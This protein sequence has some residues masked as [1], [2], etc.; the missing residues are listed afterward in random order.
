VLL[1]LL[2]N[3]AGSLQAADLP[4]PFLASGRQAQNK[5]VLRGHRDRV[6]TLAFTADGH[7]L[8]SVGQDGT[9]RIWET[10]SGR[11]VVTIRAYS[12]NVYGLAI[13]P[14]GAQLATASGGQGTEAQHQK[15]GALKLWDA[16]SGK[17]LCNFSG[18]T[19]PIYGVAFSPDGKQLASAGAD[20]TIRLWDVNGGKE[21]RTLKG[22]TDTVYAVTFSPD[23]KRLASASGDFFNNNHGQLKI[24]DAASGKDLLTLKGH[25]A[26]VYHIAFSPDGRYLASA[27]GDH[28][29]WVWDAETGQPVITLTG[30]TNQV[31]NVAFSPD[32]QR[33]VSASRDKTARVWD[34]AAGKAIFTIEPHGGE[35]Y[36]VAFAPDGRHVA[37]AGD[38]GTVRVWDVTGLPDGEWSRPPEPTPQLLQSLWADLASADP[39]EA[40]R[41]VWRATAI[42]SPVVAFLKRRLT[43]AIRTVDDKQVARL[44]ADLD[45]RKYQVR[46]KATRALEELGPLVQADLRRALAAGPSLE[47]RKRIEGLLEKLQGP[48]AADILPTLRAIAILDHVA[49][50]EARGLLEA[51][52]RGEPAARTTQEARFALQRLARR[53]S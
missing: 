17:E 38:D 48:V 23:G 11:E 20:R 46:E 9:V 21:L 25:T 50:P 37:T 22:H 51:L 5:L 29:V 40:N 8:A 39:A 26:T 2:T 36:S 10:A 43:P 41:A 13:R 42:G 47:A 6:F 15:P 14:D 28:H 45:A 34:V 35:V 49:S 33:L 52:A 30:H 12:G 31:F 3:S 16:K 19:A 24:W 44:I 1:A 27:G 18:H 4:Q 32:G 7:R 53:R